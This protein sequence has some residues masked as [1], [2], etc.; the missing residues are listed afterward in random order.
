MGVK[1]EIINDNI[2]FFPSNL[3]ERYA[4]ECIFSNI[5][6]ESTDPESIQNRFEINDEL[7]L[8]REYN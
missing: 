3:T 8:E 2:V 5:E 1:A 7:I 4:L 6:G